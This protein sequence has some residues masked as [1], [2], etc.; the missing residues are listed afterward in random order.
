MTKLFGLSRAGK[1]FE[2]KTLSEI[3][4]KIKKSRVKSVTLFRQKKKG[5]TIVGEFKRRKK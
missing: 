3:K 5:F 4:K 2:G 1:K